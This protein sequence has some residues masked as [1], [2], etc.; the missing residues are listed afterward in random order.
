[1]L[2]AVAVLLYACALSALGVLFG[3][4]TGCADSEVI[5]S[6]Y[7]ISSSINAITA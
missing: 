4:F 7:Y 1:V 3:Y 5:H 6:M 2:V